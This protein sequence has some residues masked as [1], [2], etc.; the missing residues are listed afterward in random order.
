M[1][2]KI[3]FA[4]NLTKDVEL[5]HTPQGMAIAS[6]SVASNRKIKKTDGTN[7]DET[8]FI[9]VKLF[10][11]TAEV[12]KNYLHKGSRALIEGRLVL[13]T[14]QDQANVKKHRHIIYAESLSL[15][16]KKPNASAQ[17]APETA[18]EENVPF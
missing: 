6:F 5:K 7:I 16:D 14:W 10:G 17:E 9:D 13:E 11:K 4:G 15:L 18:T 3:I 1:F 12:A 2:N 8:C